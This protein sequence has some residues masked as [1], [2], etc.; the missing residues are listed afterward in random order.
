MFTGGLIEEITGYEAART[1]T[2]YEQ[3]FKSNDE[4]L[5]WI[6]SGLILK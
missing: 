5:Y 6:T 3:E 2:K 1:G 4:F